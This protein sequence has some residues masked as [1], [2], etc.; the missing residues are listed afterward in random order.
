MDVREA[1]PEPSGRC[2]GGAVF[3]SLSVACASHQG[4]TL[5]ERLELEGPR[6]EYGV[7]PLFVALG[8]AEQRRAAVGETRHLE[9]NTQAPE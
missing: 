3:E 5:G 9:P 4:P 7:H 6:G 2:F 1:A 8:Q